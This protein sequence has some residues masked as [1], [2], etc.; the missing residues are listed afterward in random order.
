VS[1]IG[2]VQIFLHIRFGLSGTRHSLSG[3]T[4]SHLLILKKLD[5]QIFFARPSGAGDMTQSGRGVIESRLSVGECTDHARAPSD[6]AQ[7][8]LERSIGPDSAPVLLWEGIAGQRF[9]SRR[10]DKLG[11]F[12][13][14]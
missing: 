1:T 2:N 8:T 10:I 6:L 13:Q 12:G 7:D 14:P 11:S 9:S 3:D 4:F 5:I